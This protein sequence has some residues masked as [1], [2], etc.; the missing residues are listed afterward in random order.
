MSFFWAVLLALVQFQEYLL[1]KKKDTHMAWY[2]YVAFQSKRT[3]QENTY[4]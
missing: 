1:K 4:S 2:N 3:V